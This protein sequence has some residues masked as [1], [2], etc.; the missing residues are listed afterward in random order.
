MHFLF[1][2]YNPSPPTNMNYLFYRHKHLGNNFDPLR[3]SSR[4]LKK[5]GEQTD[6][7]TLLFFSWFRFLYFLG[8]LIIP[9]SHLP[10]LVSNTLVSQM[11]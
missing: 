4:Q 2:I 3:K 11:P 7:L 10:P 6:Q 9:S 1:Y 5:A 8:S